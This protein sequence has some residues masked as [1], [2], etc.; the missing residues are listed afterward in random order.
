MAIGPT[1]NGGIHLGNGWPG[2]QPSQLR[3]GR[4][5]AHTID[6][7]AIYANVLTRCLGA[8]NLSAVLSGY[9]GGM[10]DVVI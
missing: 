6:F 1:V 4:A 3:D 9:S 2:L 8:T 5:L 10:V 7:R